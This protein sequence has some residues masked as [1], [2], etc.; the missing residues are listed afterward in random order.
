MWNRCILWCKHYMTSTSSLEV[1]NL[2]DLW[3]PRFFF[4]NCCATYTV[5]QNKTAV[6]LD[7]LN[8]HNIKSALSN[9]MWR[10]RRAM[11]LVVIVKIIL[12]CL[13]D[14]KYV[15][16]GELLVLAFWSS[17]FLETYPSNMNNDLPKARDVWPNKW[18]FK[19]AIL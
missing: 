8:K 5:Q 4:N 7:R 19:L 2:L 13:N 3:N 16:L 17:D 1:H 9:T 10:F 14:N 11:N 15:R 6:A 18:W 12:E